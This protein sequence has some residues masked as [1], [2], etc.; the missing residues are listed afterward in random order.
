MFGFFKRKKRQEPDQREALERQV[1]DEAVHDVDP[2]AQQAAEYIPDDLEREAARKA[3]DGDLTTGE[4]HTALDEIPA[5]ESRDELAEELRRPEADALDDKTDTLVPPT[6]DA[7]DTEKE[8]V[9]AQAAD[10]AHEEV[11]QQEAVE[12][13]SLVDE[14]AID[15]LTATE[16][17]TASQEQPGQESPKTEKPG[18]FA[19]I[20]SGLGKTRANLTDGIAD[21]F[22]GKKQI[23]DELMED[24]ETQLLLADVG[25]EATTEI[26]D[27]LSARVS[28]K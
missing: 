20:R 26:I 6:H 9:L 7:E 12:E 19:R 14:A 15:E 10:E 17:V 25:I 13:A 23:D 11:R 8:D 2:E 21:L 1:A 22:L 3:L 28:R 24:L 18:W 16:M 4:A 5:D 27:N